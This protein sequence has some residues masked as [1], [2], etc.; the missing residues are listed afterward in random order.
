M[1]S[2]LQSSLLTWVIIMLLTSQQILGKTV[3]KD[4]DVISVLI[5]I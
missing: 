5:C 2:E 1:E 3:L 4:P